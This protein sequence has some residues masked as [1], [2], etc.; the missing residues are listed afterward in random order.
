MPPSSTP[1][2][3]R[4][5]PRRY[6]PL[7]SKHKIKLSRYKLRGTIHRNG[8]EATF[9]VMWLVTA[10]RSAEAQAASATQSDCNF[11]SGRGELSAA[12]PATASPREKTPTAAPNSATHAYAA[13]QP[14]AWWELENI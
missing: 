1:S 3:R 6:Q 8:T 7:A 13:D 5:R 10:S 12:G 2:R 14:T 11:Q 9:S 4:K